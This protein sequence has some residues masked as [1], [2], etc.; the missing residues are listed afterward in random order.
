MMDLDRKTLRSSP[1]NAPDGEALLLKSYLEV[2]INLFRGPIIRSSVPPKSLSCPHPGLSL[3][4]ERGIG[5]G[6]SIAW[7]GKFFEDVLADRSTWVASPEHKEVKVISTILHVPFDGIIVGQRGVR[8][9]A[10]RRCHA[11]MLQRGAQFMLFA[12]TQRFQ[13]EMIPS[14]LHPR[15]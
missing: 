8:R 6:N 7:N 5:F 13:G 11:G 4:P 9:R 12:Y 14:Y 1:E 15:N 3:R 2:F 10:G